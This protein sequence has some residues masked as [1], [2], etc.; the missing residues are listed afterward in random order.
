VKEPTPIVSVT[1][2]D[3]VNGNNADVVVAIERKPSGDETGLINV[4]ISPDV[5]TA[6][7]SFSFELDLHDHAGVSNDAPVRLG[8]LDGKPMPDWLSYDMSTK[9]FNTTAVPAGAFPLQLKVS[10]GGVESVVVVQEN[11]KK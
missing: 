6:G 1:P 7:S 5:A 9:K 11:Q 10:V 2:A 3:K 4:Q 8:L